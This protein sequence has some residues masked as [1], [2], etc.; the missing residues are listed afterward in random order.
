MV[1][2]YKNG[3]IITMV[4]MGNINP[5]ITLIFIEDLLYNLKSFIISLFLFI[6]NHSEGEMKNGKDK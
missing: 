1:Q 4:L 5:F 6:L 3:L 2:N